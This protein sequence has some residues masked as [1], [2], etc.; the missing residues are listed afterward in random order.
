MNKSTIGDDDARPAYTF[1]TSLM[2]FL[3]GDTIM[4]PPDWLESVD[5]RAKIV[6]DLYR[7]RKSMESREY[8]GGAYI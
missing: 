3:L 8:D 1:P 5:V 2:T 6:R 7:G 4:A